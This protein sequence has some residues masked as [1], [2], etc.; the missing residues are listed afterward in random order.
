MGKMVGLVWNIGNCW[1]VADC[2]RLAR[3]FLYFRQQ[4]RRSNM[5]KIITKMLPIAAPAVGAWSSRM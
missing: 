4:Y 1:L 3:F 2:I 5:S